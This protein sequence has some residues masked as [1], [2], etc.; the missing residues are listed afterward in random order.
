MASRKGRFLWQNGDVVI[1]RC[2]ECANYHGDGKCLAFPS[3]IPGIILRNENDHTK[4]YP[5]DNGIRFEPI[6]DKP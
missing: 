2:I 3:G 6:K 4:P 1:S 5:G